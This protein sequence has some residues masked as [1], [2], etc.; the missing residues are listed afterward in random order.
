MP[1]AEYHQQIENERLRTALADAIAYLKLMPRAPVT[2]AKIAELEKS[3]NQRN[4]VAEIEDDKEWKIERFTPAGKAIRI[5]FADGHLHFETEIPLSEGVTF[6]E[7]L[8]VAQLDA[9]ID[10][11]VARRKNII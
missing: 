3:L 10:A 8:T 4:T 5:R 2:S 11:L 7:E 9:L 6:G 1:L